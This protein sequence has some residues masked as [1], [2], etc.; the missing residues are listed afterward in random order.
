MF[1]TSWD[2]LHPVPLVPPVW[3][4]C[5]FVLVIFKFD[6]SHTRSYVSSSDF[7]VGMCSICH[8]CF[9]SFSLCRDR[10][11]KCVV[12]VLNIVLGIGVSSFSIGCMMVY[13][14]LSGGI[15]L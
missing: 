4:S 12:P 15:F 14:L 11:C 10:D 3:G 2:V 9:L 7:C 5:I 8:V 1:S 13:S 6:R